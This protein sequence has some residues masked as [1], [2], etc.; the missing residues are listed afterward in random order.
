MNILSDRLAARLPIF[1]GYVMMPVAMMMQICT[2]PGQT[3]AV[4]AFAP[5]IRES[6][7]L[8]DSRLSLAYM[9]GT[10]LAAVPLSFVG[11]I[12]DKWGLRSTSFV[13]TAALVLTCFLA[14]MVGG[15]ASLF[16]AFFFLRF[17]G[18]GA[19]TLLSGNSVAMWFRTKIGRVSAVMSIG[20]AMTFAFVPGWINHSIT[21]RGWRDTFQLIA[22][23]LVAT[24]FPLLIFLFRNRPEDIGQVVDGGEKHAAKSK[25]DLEKRSFTLAEALRDRTYYIL[26]VTMTIWAMAGTGIVFY[27]FVLCEDRGLA[28]G[29]AAD[30]FKTF[31]LSML[32]MQLVGGVMADYLPLHRLL[33]V[34]VAMLGVGMGLLVG[35]DLWMLHGLGVLFGGGQGLAIAVGAV[36]WVRYYGREHIGSIRGSAWSCTVAGS[37]CGP[38]LMGVIHDLHGGF[39]PAIVTFLGIISVLAIAVWWAT[40]PRIASAESASQSN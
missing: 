35:E 23:I 12:S 11:P 22:V 8:S 1:Y 25:P 18:Q 31:G 13:A 28:D 32:V 26:T 16:L 29:V 7:Q 40:P 24:L 37:G 14:S 30:F 5:A 4:S 9:L 39:G 20:T 38:L 3:F 21:T 19:L 34:G 33:G 6:L 15:F 17:L 36:V 2:S 27:M 10:V